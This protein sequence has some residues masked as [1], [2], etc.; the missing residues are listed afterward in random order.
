MP[1]RLGL[2]LVLAFG[3]LVAYLAAFNPARIRIVLGPSLAYELP[4]M[5][6]LAGAFLAG[7]CLAVFFTLLRDLGRSVG[8]YR[9]ARR[10]RRA[11]RLAQ[12]YQRGLEAELAGST[13]AAAD[14]YKQLLAKES[15]HPEAHLRLGELARARG[16]VQTA[17][18]HHLEA[19]RSGGRPDILLAVAEDY[20]RAGRIEDA[21]ATYREIIQRDKA[22]GRALR[23]IRGLLTSAGRWEE[24]LEIQERIGSLAAR[25]ERSAERE[26]LAGIQYE[27]GKAR[28]AQG[29]LAEA[30]R[31]F[32]EALKTDRAFL[33]AHLALGEAW[34][35][36]GDRREAVRTWKRAA[37]V[38][39]APVLLRRLEQAYRAEGRPTQMIALYQEAS[40]RAPQDLALAFS[41]GR[42]YFEL[43]MLDEAADQFQK[44][45]V[46]APDLAPLH[47]FLGAIYER[48]GQAAAAFEEYHRALRLRQSF[49]WPH[50]CSVCGT[51][52]TE[53]QDRCPTCGRW[54]TLTA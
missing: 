22:N 39:T 48:R 6:V 15:E 5:A 9:L 7:A 41:L 27:I 18:S 49:D 42:V 35:R 3:A 19:L 23:A 38:L 17:L 53:W 1:L 2:L 37:E 24:A 47:A 45:E 11:E 33:P 40:E 34:E 21:L 4:M 50:R 43:E 25:E 44:V 10:A 26:W 14:A 36:A 16:D 30:R 51:T 8:D 54:N 28:L 20:Q 29:K 13:A 32:A 52:Q 31:Y 46:R 12:A